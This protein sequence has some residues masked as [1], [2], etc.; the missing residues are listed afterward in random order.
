MGRPRLSFGLGLAL[1][2]TLGA[3]GDLCDQA[4]RVTDGANDQAR[5]CVT[6]NGDLFA[7]FDTSRCEGGVSSCTA[8]DR[9]ALQAY[10]VCLD[11]VQVC[12]PQSSTAFS[13]S[14][15]ACMTAHL[16]AVGMGCQQAFGFSAQ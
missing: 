16:T 8:S 6:G 14:V 12:S 15:S 10:Y 2:A 11:S 3:C 1:A 9:A 4:E 13:G 7:P 5:A